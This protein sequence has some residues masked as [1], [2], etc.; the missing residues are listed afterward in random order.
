MVFRVVTWIITVIIGAV[1]A[2]CPRCAKTPPMAPPPPP[3]P[4]VPGRFLRVDQKCKSQSGP[5]LVDDQTIMN[6]VLQ[7]ETLNGTRATGYTIACFHPCLYANG[8]TYEYT[9]QL[10]QTLVIRHFNFMIGMRRK[11]L[12]LLKERLW[13]PSCPRLRGGGRSARR[14]DWALGL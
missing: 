5:N 12:L 3:L 14:R 2:L 4:L 13:R 11:K 8:A 9:Q 10:N 1:P 7:T 6:D